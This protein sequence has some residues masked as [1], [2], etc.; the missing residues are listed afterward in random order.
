MQFSSG[1]WNLAE[2]LERLPANQ[3]IKTQ[4]VLTHLL[5]YQQERLCLKEPVLVQFN[6]FRNA[7][8]LN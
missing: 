3:A 4:A 7:N 2:Y 1:G 5:D 8:V 6:T